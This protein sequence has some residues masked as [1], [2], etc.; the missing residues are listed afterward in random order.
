MGKI[1]K[2]THTGTFRIYHGD[3]FYIGFVL[4]AK[5]VHIRCREKIETK[6]FKKH[7]VLKKMARFCWVGIINTCW[8]FMGGFKPFKFFFFSTLQLTFTHKTGWPLASFHSRRIKT[9]E[10]S[11]VVAAVYSIPCCASRFAQDD[12]EE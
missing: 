11:K 7:N 2:I 1:K 5:G 4:N 3:I 10:K 12:F 8:W 6:Y 9:E